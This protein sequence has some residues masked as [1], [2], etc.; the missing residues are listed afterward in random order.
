MV[1][2]NIFRR[3]PRIPEKVTLGRF[4][5]ERDG[6]VAYLEYSLAGDVLTLIHTEVPA[7][8]R[9]LGLASSLVETALRWAR[10]NKAKVDVVCPIVA[11]YLVKHP[12]YSNLI[13]R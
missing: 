5:I 4:E 12:E 3:K 1:A 10:E 9:G 6:E 13:L 7:K 11:E 8:L 2:W